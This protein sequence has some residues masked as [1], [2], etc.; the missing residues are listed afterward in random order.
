MDNYATSFRKA[1]LLLVSCLIFLL[2]SAH[3]LDISDITLPLTRDAADRSLSKD[4]NYAML[5][6]GSVRRTWEMNDK[7]VFIDFDTNTNEAILVAIA[8]KKPVEK[9]VGIA[10][11]H[12]L[13]KGMFSEDATWDAPKD[14]TA[15]KMISESFGLSNARRKKLN[16]KAMLF[17][18]LN[19][20]GARITRVSFFSLMPKTNRWLLEEMRPDAVGTAMSTNWGREHIQAI[21]QDE[22]RRQAIPLSTDAAPEVATALETPADTTAADATSD[23]TQV[24]SL[25]PTVAPKP[26]PKPTPEPT[27]K[28][29]TPAADTNSTV[30]KSPAGTARP[31][32]PTSTKPARGRRTAMGARGGSGSGTNNIEALTPGAKLQPGVTVKKMIHEGQEGKKVAVSTLP[33]PPN[34]LKSVGIEEPTW[35]HYIGGGIIL[36]LILA[37]IIRSVLQANAKAARQKQFNQVLAQGQPVR[38]MPRR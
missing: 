36:L 2:G 38:R 34:W 1:L 37:F 17:Y 18:E 23:E 16:N 35:A 4:Y 31:A 29:P 11:A 10:D 13:A 30:T 6:D 33:P 25:T 32:S 26:T 24:I 20:K 8:Y 7:T 12:T 21:Y 22:A 15:R 3:A 14:S 19:D 5:A 28:T 9:K 27:G